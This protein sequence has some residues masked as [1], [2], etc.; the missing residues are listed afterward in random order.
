MAGGKALESGGVPNNDQSEP[1]LAFS[2][3]VGAKSCVE[4]RGARGPVDQLVAK[5]WTM[6]ATVPAGSDTWCI[7]MALR[8]CCAGS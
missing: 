6:A 8:S 1:L 2:L 4:A 7:G 5:H 3:G